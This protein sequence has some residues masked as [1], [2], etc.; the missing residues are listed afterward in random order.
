MKRFLA[1]LLFAALP[2]KADGA[3][4]LKEKIVVTEN[5]VTLGDLLQT[6][7][8]QGQTIVF[9]APTPGASGA[10]N[11]TR[12]IAAAKTYGLAA[13]AP[14][15]LREIRVEREARKIPAADI[16]QAIAARAAQH[17]RAEAPDIEIDFGRTLGDLD[18]EKN[19]GAPLSFS[20][21]RLEPQSGRFEARLFVPES[22]VLS[23]STPAIITGTLFEMSE[24][25]QLKHSVGR[26]QIIAASDVELTRI[27]HQQLGNNLLRS[28][29][30]VVGMAAKRSISED[31][32]LHDNDLEKA[33]IIDRNEMVLIVYETPAL[34]V[35][36]RGKALAGGAMGDV[37]DVMN[38]QSKHTIQATIVGSGKVAVNS[39]VPMRRVAQVSGAQVT[40][41]N[42]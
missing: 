27:R 40:T 36:T 15:G 1:L 16:K 34:T 41:K 37:I 8:A 32:I 35:T 30:Q 33:K 3:V 28:L 10:I 22:A 29:D 9:G 4:A 31:A 13:I 39:I 38:L 18:V 5:V 21:F 20:S 19:N 11:V 17:L 12:A 14:P 2:A 25:A 7:V 42:D 6:P 23:E 24:V 26:G